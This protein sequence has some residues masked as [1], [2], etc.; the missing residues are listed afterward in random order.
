[1]T[2]YLQG[3]SVD[4]AS[5]VSTAED[6]IILLKN[7]RDNA[8]SEFNKGFA[9]AKEIADAVGVKIEAPRVVPHQKHRENHQSNSP[10]EYFRKS[11]FIPLVDHFIHA[12]SD[13]FLKHKRTLSKIQNIIPDKLVKL[14]TKNGH[15]DDKAIS[16]IIIETV[17]IL[18]IQWPTVTTSIGSI[19][20]KEIL[21][22]RQ[23]W[24]AVEERPSNFIDALN[25]CDKALFPHV[26]KF[27][28]IGATLAVT[29][30][31]NERS[32]STLRRLKDWQRNTI[33]EERLN[34]CA[35]LSIHREIDVT[36]E[37]VID[38][39][40]EKRRKFPL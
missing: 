32:F 9:A 35:L 29:I 16:D 31:S 18:L 7:I 5:A 1:M 36:I 14:C 33:G 38:K 4:L 6:L 40:A 21:L 25:V 23:R 27:L 34:S 15:E 28:K 26:H 19:I 3:K 37:E 12:L 10:E 11:V 24:I 20:K 22:W 17:E 13:R 39:F 8:S 2:T 30:A